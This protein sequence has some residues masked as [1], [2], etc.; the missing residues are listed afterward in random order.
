MPPIELVP[1]T[2]NDA[3]E[4]LGLAPATRPW[5]DGYPTDGDVEVA[6]W[7]VSGVMAPVTAQDPFGPWL[8]VLD[9]GLVVGGV[10]FHG[11]PDEQGRAEIGYGIAASVRGRGIATAAVAHLRA[12]P[13]LPG[14]TCLAAHTDPDN[15]ASQR[16][17]ER[18]GFTRDGADDE[19]LRWVLPVGDDEPTPES[20]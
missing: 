8:V 10:G 12:L 3:D 7:L 14:V 16:V 19:G 5:A 2:R 4:V 15:R 11:A 13:A 17:L 18:N 6:G 1:M 9:T 20:A